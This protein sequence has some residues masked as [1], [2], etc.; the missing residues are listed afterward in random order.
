MAGR[1]STTDRLKVV[2]G[3]FRKDR[4]RNTEKKQS[5][6]GLK[7]PS[8]LPEEAATYFKAIQNEMKDIGQD[9]RTFS[10]LA[11]LAAIRMAEIQDL[12]VQIEAEGSVLDGG[13]IPHKNPAVSQRN[14]ALR[15]LQSLLSELGLTP[16]ALGRIGKAVS[17]NKSPDGF[18]DL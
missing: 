13:S 18:G 6:A 1:K 15:H 16:T 3:T 4:A 12:N 7:A 17:E 2:K 14:E 11:S 5:K 8:W 9:S 10:C